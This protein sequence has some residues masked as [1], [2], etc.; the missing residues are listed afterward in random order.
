MG[1]GVISGGYK[2]AEEVHAIDP[3]LALL[4]RFSKENYPK[5][6][7]MISTFEQVAKDKGC[8]T[9]QLAMAWVLSRGE[10]VFVIP[11]TR[12]I[13]YLEENLGVVNVK[14]TKEEEAEIRRAISETEVAGGR[15]T[16]A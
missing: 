10:D 1:R 9:G 11:G 4:P 16:D 14:L 6:L 3:F 12:K 8:T 2:T 15:Y 13:K 5:V 7:D